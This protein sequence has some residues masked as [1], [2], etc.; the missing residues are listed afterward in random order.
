MVK[1]LTMEIIPSFGVP[2]MISSYNGTSFSCEEVR[3]VKKRFGIRHK[4]G[5]A[6]H[7]VSQELVERANC[8]I[9]EELVK[10]C[11]VTTLKVD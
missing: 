7:P 1:W 11:A 6:Y 9:K 2:E 8:T 5:A 10:V 3:E 4:F